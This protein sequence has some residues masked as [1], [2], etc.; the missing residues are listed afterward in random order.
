[1]VC[2]NIIHTQ[3]AAIRKA[4]VVRYEKNTWP[5]KNAMSACAL[6]IESLHSHR[7]NRNKRKIEE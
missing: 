4:R 3:R 2:K 1:M 5:L 6:S 7:F